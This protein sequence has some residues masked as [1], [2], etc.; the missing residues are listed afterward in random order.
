MISN[1]DLISLVREDVLKVATRMDK[2]A[3]YPSTTIAQILWL[4]H[5]AKTTEDDIVGKNNPLGITESDGSTTRTFNSI[6]EC[7]IVGDNFKIDSA[8]FDAKKKD[9]C[10]TNKLY[11]IDKL[12]VYN[13]DNN[14]VDLSDDKKQPKVDNYQV[15]KD[16]TTVMKTDSVEDALKQAQVTGATV[17][18]SKGATIS[19]AIIANNKIGA[20]SYSLLAGAAVDCISV[21][22]YQ[23]YF[24]GCPT[25]AITG[26][27]YLYDGIN[28][29]DRF[30]ICAKAEDANTDT[31]KIIGFINRADINIK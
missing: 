25:R 17:F 8:D 10:K 9:I 30:A 23:K 11:G 15:K 6:E 14:E 1:K 3:D 12:Y 2:A 28:Y 4:H 19:N 13:K 26:K 29:N 7:L 31:S 27:Y 5:E 22:L 21:N 20:V 16:N 24:A 18:N